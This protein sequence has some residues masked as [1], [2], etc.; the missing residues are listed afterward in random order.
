MARRHISGNRTPETSSGGPRA[1]KE[2]NGFS[3]LRSGSGQA[4]IGPDV[5]R[6]TEV[7]AETT[8]GG[9][10]SGCFGIVKWH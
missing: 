4:A 6:D 5:A 3:A 7:A 1:S 2:S 8:K 10:E 9:K